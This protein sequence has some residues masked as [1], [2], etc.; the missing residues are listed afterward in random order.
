MLD[1][2]DDLH[3]NT[4]TTLGELSRQTARNS[5]PDPEDRRFKMITLNRRGVEFAEKR[6][7]ALHG[8]QER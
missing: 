8:G 2:L 4:P 7:E 6:K 1:Y 3:T 5:I